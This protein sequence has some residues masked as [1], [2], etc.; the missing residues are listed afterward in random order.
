MAFSSSTI[1][2]E[3]QLGVNREQ[4]AVCLAQ[5]S[6]EQAVKYR[7]GSMEQTIISCNEE[8]KKKHLKRSMEQ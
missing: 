7:K 8:Q 5:R 6:N 3:A 4:K 1:I 2:I